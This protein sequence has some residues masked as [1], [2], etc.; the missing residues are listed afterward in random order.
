MIRECLLEHASAMEAYRSIFRSKKQTL[1]AVMIFGHILL[2]VLSR[3]VSTN[4]L[5]ALSVRGGLRCKPNPN[6]PRTMGLGDSR[7]RICDHFVFTIMHANYIRRVD[8]RYA[9]YVVML[10]AFALVG[11]GE[12]E[13]VGF[14]K[15][16]ISDY[17]K[18]QP[19]RSF[20][21]FT[22]G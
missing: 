19:Q 22:R 12:D 15:D 13:T 16:E 6:P 3:D 7:N 11:C 5:I 2:K 10:L 8:M 9:I 18:E 4:P 21:I 1:W 17:A 20:R 14:S